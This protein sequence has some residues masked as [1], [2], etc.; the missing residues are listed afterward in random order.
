MRAKGFKTQDMPAKWEIHGQ[1]N[2][3]QSSAF[4]QQREK[5]FVSIGLK[6]RRVWWQCG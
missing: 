4:L 3:A 2:N 6:S 5:L 1:H